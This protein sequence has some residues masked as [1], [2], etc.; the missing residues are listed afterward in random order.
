IKRALKGLIANQPGS[1]MDGLDDRFRPRNRIVPKRR[2][3]A[4]A[5][6]KFQRIVGK[7]LIATEWV[8]RRPQPVWRN[9]SPKPRRIVSC[10]VIVESAF[11]IPLLPRIA[12]PLGRF[13]L[14]AHRLISRTAVG[15]IFL[16]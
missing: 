7:S 3:I 4:I 13:R 5:V 15:R 6:D 9:P 2:S 1:L 11:L 12:I 10:A 16:I 14:I 8:R